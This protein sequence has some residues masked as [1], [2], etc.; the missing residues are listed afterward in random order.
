MTAASARQ[1]FYPI[2][3]SLRALAVTSVVGYHAGLAFLPGGYVGVDVFFVISGFL[4]INHIIEEQRTGRFTFAGFYARRALR[5]LPPYFVVI[6][7]CMVVAPFVLVLPK[8]FEAFRDEVVWSAAMAA[9]YLFLGQ[10]GYFDAS[11]NTKILLHLWSLAVEEQ[12]YLV[13]PLTIIGLWAVSRSL[14]RRA[15][16]W[17]WSL[18]AATIFVLSFALCIYFTDGGKNHA[19][20]QMPLRAWEFIAGGVLGA[21]IVQAKRLP[22]IVSNMALLAGIALIGAAIGFFNHD[23]PFPSY[24]AAIPVLGTC[25]T[26]VG[27]VAR[28]DGIARFLSP[29]PV[30][31]VGLVSYSWYLWHWPALIFARI[32]TFQD[33]SLARDLVMAGAALALAFATYFLVEKPFAKLRSIKPAVARSWWPT[34]VSVHVSCATAIACTFLAAMWA[35]DAMRTIPKGFLQQTTMRFSSDCALDYGPLTKKCGEQRNFKATG[36]LIGDS[37]AMSIFNELRRTANKQ[38]VQL[39]SITNP[40]CVPYIGIRAYTHVRA[41]QVHCEKAMEIALNEIKAMRKPPDFAILYGFWQNYTYF[42]ETIYYSGYQ[43]KLSLAGESRPWKDQ[44]EIFIK[45]AQMTIQKLEELGVKRILIVGPNPVLDHEAPECLARAHKYSIDKN[46]RCGVDRAI[47]DSK[48]RDSMA[49]LSQAI[50]GPA[51]LAD[52]IGGL[53]TEQICFAE[54]SNSALYFDDDHLSDSGAR[55]LIDSI[56]PDLLWAFTGA[57]PADRTALF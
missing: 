44:K 17:F 54:K 25:L 26:I 8:E 53:C 24:W 4:I 28:P 38:G 32:Y 16:T 21:A 42:K 20:Y 47:V 19:F 10:Q 49:W 37:H 2:V 50:I 57:E 48:R 51:R 9:N 55:L 36:V 45:G 31:W 7:S 40:T 41:Q 23:T 33:Q 29:R 35:A 15:V 14:P 43:T 18:A 13:A 11:A 5:I 39:A 34:S 12:F 27:G 46:L 22:A 52:P 1:K 30:L 3:N 56:L 6:A